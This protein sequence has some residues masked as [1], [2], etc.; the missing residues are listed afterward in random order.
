VVTEGSTS[1]P[2]W[3][4]G[5][6]RGKRGSFPVNHVE[7]LKAMEYPPAYPLAPAISLPKPVA[8]NTPT[9]VPSIQNPA[10]NYNRSMPTYS[11]RW[12][13]TELKYKVGIFLGVV[14]FIFLMFALFVPWYFSF[15]T[16]QLMNIFQWSGISGYTLGTVNP[17]FAMLNTGAGYTA[18]VNLG[19]NN[20][21]GVMA[22]SITFLVLA[23]V[24]NIIL[25]VL[26]Y[27]RLREKYFSKKTMLGMAFLLV[28]FV[29]ISPVQFL[30]FGQAYAL[31]VEPGAVSGPGT[32]LS[33]TIQGRLWG[34]GFGWMAALISIGPSAAMFFVA[35]FATN[36]I[37]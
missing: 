35:L 11:G 30:R 17:W 4:R 15:I 34:P 7:I 5:E 13:D 29:I 18:Y 32:A 28:V 10:N 9:V 33:G 27:L 26:F 6:L 12:E 22:I 19:F 2:E 1:G 3:W 36:E 16:G 8:Y 23:I 21:N 31:E 14:N 37:R 24:A 20:V 25:T